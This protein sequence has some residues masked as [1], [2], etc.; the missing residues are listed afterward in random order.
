ML[1]QSSSSSNIQVSVAQYLLYI[2]YGDKFLLYTLL[3]ST[4]IRLFS[5]YVI[6]STIIV[7]IFEFN[8]TLTVTKWFQLPNFHRSKQIEED[9][10]ELPGSTQRLQSIDQ[11]THQSKP[12]HHA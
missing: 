9:S 10:K 2:K 11:H 3:S 8:N 12:S 4:R 1:L 5:A 6:A 7:I